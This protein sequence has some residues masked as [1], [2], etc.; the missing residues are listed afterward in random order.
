MLSKKLSFI[1]NLYSPKE[2]S[3]TVD[4]SVTSPKPHLSCR[5][6]LVQLCSPSEILSSKLSL[7]VWKVSRV[8]CGLF[9]VSGHWVCEALH[10]STVALPQA[11]RSTAAPPAVNLLHGHGSKPLQYIYDC[12]QKVRR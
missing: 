7:D 12:Y 3:E 6:D 5:L 1:S 4:K 8:S 9:Y 11:S 10:S 2:F